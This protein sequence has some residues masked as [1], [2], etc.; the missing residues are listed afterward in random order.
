M[1]K[2]HQPQS[3]IIKHHQ[4]S[5]TIIHQQA[6]SG[7]SKYQQASN[8]IKHRASANIS[9]HQTSSN[10]IMH[11]INYASNA[12]RIPWINC[13]LVRPASAAICWHEAVA[14]RPASAQQW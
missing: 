8:I 5:S 12:K 14:K 1:I 7:I 3:N 4:T 6:S 9:K 13:S 2:H 10:I 11:P